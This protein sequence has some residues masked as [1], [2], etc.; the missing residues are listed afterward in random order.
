MGKYSTIGS[1]L[2]ALVLL[3]LS[4]IA[5]IKV[6][7]TL[8]VILFVLCHFNALICFILAYIEVRSWKQKLSLEDTKKQTRKQ[9]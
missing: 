1:V 7:P 4:T 3:S 2:I 5:T 9:L 6:Y 8:S